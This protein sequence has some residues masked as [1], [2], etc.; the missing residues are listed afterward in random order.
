MDS[1]KCLGVADRNS[2]EKGQGACRKPFLKSWQRSVDDE[3]PTTPTCMTQRFLLVQQNIGIFV[4]C[5]PRRTKL[6]RW[7]PSLCNSPL[8]EFMTIYILYLL[9][10][11]YILYIY[12]LYISFQTIMLFFTECMCCTG[13]G[14]IVCIEA[15][16]EQ[17]LN[18][19]LYFFM[20]EQL[21]KHFASLGTVSSLYI[22]LHSDKPSTPK[23]SSVE[24]DYYLFKTEMTR[25]QRIKHL[26]QRFAPKNRCRQASATKTG[27]MRVTI[28]SILRFKKPHQPEELWLKGRQKDHNLTVCYLKMEW[29]NGNVMSS[30][31]DIIQTSNQSK[32]NMADH[33]C[34]KKKTLESLT[35]PSFLQE[36]WTKCDLPWDSSYQPPHGRRVGTVSQNNRSRKNILPDPPVRV[37]KFQPPKWLVW[38]FGAS[39]ATG[40]FRVI[41]WT[42]LISLVARIFFAPKCWCFCA[43]SCE[44]GCPKARSHKATAF[45]N[46]IIF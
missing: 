14:M 8:A 33:R 26:V 7:W 36:S 27:V 11:Y 4:L 23:C 19:L 34:Q 28:S 5:R 35:G 41:T 1:P 22:F 16:I 21:C 18:T 13:F 45:V 10:I 9:Y 44:T 42:R 37:S 6:W 40:G 43:F 38:F 24:D 39:R 2:V 12:I 46:T 25:Y 3:W 31:S 32:K 15:T 29:K 30:T 20:F 17:V